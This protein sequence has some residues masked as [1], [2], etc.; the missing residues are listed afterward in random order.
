[1]QVFSEVDPRVRRL[2]RDFDRLAIKG[3]GLVDD[4]GLPEQVGDLLDGHCVGSPA[5]TREQPPPDRGRCLAVL[6]FGRRRVAQDQAA[7]LAQMIGIIRLD[8]VELL[9]VCQDISKL[10]LLDQDADQCQAQ[11]DLPGGSHQALF[12]SSPSVGDAAQRREMVRQTSQRVQ[13]VGVLGDLP[14]IIGDQAG[15][16]VVAQ[17]DLLQAA[18][19]VAVEPV[20]TRQV[21]EQTLVI[22]DSRRPAAEP[23]LEICRGDPE[24][25]LLEPFVGILGQ[26]LIAGEGRLE[27]AVLDQG[28]RD[29]LA[30]TDIVGELLLQASPDRQRLLGPLA[31]RWRRPS[32]W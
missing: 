27:L 21:G 9:V 19:G 32:A 29:P 2:G 30:H 23:S 25:R 28:G 14:V 11:L 8:P 24:E 22:G 20:V 13:V 15:T 12:E 1:M 31:A 5:R 17:E 7:P 18:A 26:S 10:L 4:A 3:Q 16:V 6:W